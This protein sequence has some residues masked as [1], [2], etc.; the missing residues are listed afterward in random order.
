MSTTDT[1][2]AE[3]AS[4]DDHPNQRAFEGHL[5]PQAF[6]GLDPLAFGGL[7][8]PAGPRGRPGDAGALRP[9]T[10]AAATPTVSGLALD[11]PAR[12]LDREF[13]PGRLVRFEDIDFPSALTHEP[14]RHFLCETGLPEDTALFQLDTD[15]PLPTLAEYYADD[16]RPEV[17]PSPDLL[18][19]HAARLIRL[20]DLDEQHAVL[21]DGATGAILTWRGPGTTPHP[22]STDVSTFALTLCLL[23]HDGTHPE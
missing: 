12:L 3:T 14:T 11:L 21:L 16:H 13:G 1:A 9:L 15:I 7:L 18:P 2:V 19:P 4:I 6:D 8:R 5:N 20:G 17:A 23:H 22:L 10:G